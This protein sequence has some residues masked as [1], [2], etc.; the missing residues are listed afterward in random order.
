MSSLPR[1]ISFLAACLFA[2]SFTA[3][4]MA[5]Q[6]PKGAKPTDPKMVFS[7]YAGKTSF[8]DRGG[9]AYWK[10]DGTFQGTGKDPT[11]IGL[12]KWTVNTKSRLCADVNWFGVKDGKQ[13]SE[14][15]QMCFDFVTAPDGTIW[16][17]N[18]GEK[19]EWY[20][21][22]EAKQKNGDQNSKQVN[23]MRKQYGV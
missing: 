23:K 13:V 20:R 6:K 15:F 11:W 17:K 16:E 18:V 4:A 9:T 8:W 22:K 14:P 19:S 3:P 2:V 12:G 7:L 1:P 5:D 21:H 10:A